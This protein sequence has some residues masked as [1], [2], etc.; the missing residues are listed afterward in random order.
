MRHLW[1]NSKLEIADDQTSG[2]EMSVIH[3][4]LDIIGYCVLG[5][6]SHF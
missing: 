4:Y 1:T 6:F 3:S 5:D 2:L